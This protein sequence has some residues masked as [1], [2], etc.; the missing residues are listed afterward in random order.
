M[1]SYAA[2]QS[3]SAAIVDGSGDAILYGG[4]SE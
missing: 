2:W 3:D 1:P 4:M